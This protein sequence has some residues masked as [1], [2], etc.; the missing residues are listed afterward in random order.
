MEP[1]LELPL[2]SNSYAGLL[3]DTSDASKMPP[4]PGI[5]DL[6]PMTSRELQAFAASV[7]KSLGVSRVHLDVRYWRRGQIDE[8][9]G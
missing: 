1:W 4:W 6:T 5:K 3:N 9:A 7:A 2:D 8:L